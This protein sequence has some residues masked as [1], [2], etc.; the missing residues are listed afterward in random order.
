MTVMH[1]HVYLSLNSFLCEPINATEH[2]E[3]STFTT[4][5][6]SGEKSHNVATKEYRICLV[7]VKSTFI[8]PIS[9][10]KD[11]IYVHAI[12]NR[13]GLNA[14]QTLYNTL[15]YHCWDPKPNRC[16]LTNHIL[17]KLK[18]KSYKGT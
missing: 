3:H 5:V 1:L 17:S 7:S 4:G 8:C 9:T 16:Q 18:S 12:V 14:S 15:H 11:T 13:V 10:L 2:S 6:D